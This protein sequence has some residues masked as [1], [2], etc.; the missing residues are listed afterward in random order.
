MARDGRWLV[1]ARYSS[2]PMKRSALFLIAT[3]SVAAVVPAAD[4][5][6]RTRVGVDQQRQVGFTMTGRSVL[7]NLRPIDGQPNPL[8]AELSGTDVVLAC[9]GKSPANGRDRIADQE[10]SWPMGATSFT[11]KLSRD[12]SDGPKWCVLERPDGTDLAVTLKLRVP[13]PA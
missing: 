2:R 1:V 5:G 10:A 11:G 4:A 8:V 6:S 3:A 13:K 12:I 9:R 7:V